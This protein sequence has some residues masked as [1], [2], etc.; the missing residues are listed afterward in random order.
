[1]LL[2]WL[3]LNFGVM[4]SEMFLVFGGVLGSLVSIRCMMFLVRLCLLV[5]MK[6]LVLVIE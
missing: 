3:I 4:N 2:L 1:M 6:I 5:V